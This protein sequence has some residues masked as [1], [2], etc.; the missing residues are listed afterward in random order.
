V[1][2]ITESFRQAVTNRKSKQYLHNT[3]LCRYIYVLGGGKPPEQ[4]ASRVSL[5][6]AASRVG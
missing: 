4:P 3:G 6:L 1:K 5:V 2:K